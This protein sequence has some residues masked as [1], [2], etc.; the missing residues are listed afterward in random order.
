MNDYQKNG[1]TYPHGRP[2]LLDHHGRPFDQSRLDKNGRP[3][4][5]PEIGGIA[6]PHSFTFI[7]RSGGAYNTYWHER[8]DEALRHSRED[9]RVMKRDAYLMSLLRERKDAVASLNW[10]LEVP[11]PRD[12]F[13]MRI[14]DRVT[15]LIRGIP[16]LDRIIGW[17]LEA[18]W[19]G[20]YGVQVEWDWTQVQDRGKDGRPDGRNRRGVTIAQAWPVNGDKIGF[21]YDH[22]PYIQVSSEMEGKFPNADIIST[23]NGRAITLR[24]TWRDRFILHRHIMEDF[25]YFD[26]DQAG[27]IH[28]VGVRSVLFWTN[29]LKLEWLSSITDFFDRIGLGFTQW[30]YPAGNPQ[31]KAQAEEAARSQ[32]SRSHLLVPVWGESGKDALTGVERVEVPTAGTEALRSLIEYLDGHIERYVV[33]QSGSSRSAPSGIGNEAATEFQISTKAS[34]TL[35]DAKNLAVSL[36]GSKNEPGIV[37]FI[38]KYS[39]PEADFPIRWVF[40]VE[41]PQSESKL[42]SVRTLVDFGLEIKADEVR[43]AAG[44]SKPSEGDELIKPPTPPGGV[45]A[46]PGMPSPDGGDPAAGGQSPEGEPGEGDE[47]ESGDFLEALRMRRGEPQRYSASDQVWRDMGFVRMSATGLPLHRWYSPTTRQSRIQSVPPGQG[48]KGTRG[49]VSMKWQ[50]APKEPRLALGSA[51]LARLEQALRLMF[52]GWVTA[53]SLPKLIG[54]HDGSTVTAD[55]ARGED[56]SLDIL[57]SDGEASWK[58]T[59]RPDGDLALVGA[60]AENSKVGRAA[61][62]AIVAGVD[63]LE[64]EEEE[65]DLT[66]PPEDALPDVSVRDG[67]DERRERRLSM[68]DD[69][70]AEADQLFPPEKALSGGS[71]AHKYSS[72]QFDIGESDPLL[73]R[74]LLKLGEKIAEQDLA[75]D[76]R[77]DAPHITCRFGLHGHDPAEVAKIVSNFGPVKVRLG[78]ISVFEV[79]KPG[80]NYDVVK[81]DVI[82]DDLHELHNK[83]AAL[84]HTDTHP[85]YQPHITLSYV[86][87]GLGKEYAGPSGLEG[88]EFTS[89]AITFSDRHRQKSRIPLGRRETPREQFSRLDRAVRYLRERGRM[90][91]ADHLIRVAD[92]MIGV[93]R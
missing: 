62:A 1:T 49:T 70:L 91:E 92:S 30:R 34:I 43:A 47:A 52:D 75:D 89:D 50:K 88:T 37:N 20:R 28:G 31:A 53:S 72:T 81:I 64:T 33:G 58:L 4:G 17:L 41:N 25:D 10:H 87:P 29:W 42:N 11:D 2:Q 14:K 57:A 77:E 3:D 51:T 26:P 18:I 56:R 63:G 86:K 65:F 46:P 27:G 66:D 7:A 39:A 23:T 60:D 93:S 84:P 82:G 61:R 79:R 13:Q 48:K 71:E 44:Y 9:A 21:Q 55:V 6:L 67:N 15:R 83:L 40:D 19:F 16:L 38:Q 12:P 76:G 35:G 73:A 32:S 69:I 36:S 8:Y 5:S 90:E 68:I 22:T 59:L 24:G 45:G 54:A 80:K 74:R 78:G 85:T